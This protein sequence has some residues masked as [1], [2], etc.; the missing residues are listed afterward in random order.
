MAPSSR[1][2]GTWRASPSR[3][4]Q[5]HP[6]GDAVAVPGDDPGALAGVGRRQLLADERVEQ[7]R[8]AGLHLAGDGDPQ[9]LVE[10]G[11][12]TALQAWTASGV[13]RVR[14]ATACV[15]QRRGRCRAASVDVDDGHG[16]ARAAGRR[17]SA[18][19]ATGVTPVGAGRRCA[20]SSASTSRRRVLPRRRRRT[21]TRLLARPPAPRRSSACSSSARRGEVVAQLALDAAQRV[22][23]VLADDEADLVDVLAD[24]AWRAW[25]R[26]MAS[27]R[28][29]S[30][31]SALRPM[32][33]PHEPTGTGLT[34][35][36]PAHAGRTMPNISRPP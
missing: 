7:R 6:V 17:A 26:R 22:A 36:R 31:F 9:R 8:L 28:S 19:G 34:R 14:P 16:A 5:R 4:V 3:G 23:G 30:S 10:A 11:R 2:N 12:S 35:A 32:S 25:L 13:A 1:V 21:C 27:W 33:R 24:A 18:S 15:E 29:F 20:C